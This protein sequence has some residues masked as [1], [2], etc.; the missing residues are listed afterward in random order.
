MDRLTDREGLAGIALLAMFADGLVREEED[1]E[2]REALRGTEAFADASD[3][4][5]G[6][7]LAKLEQL[8][9][10]MGQERFLRACCE[11]V[12]GDLADVAYGIAWDII[13][14]D[15]EVAPEESELLGKLEE[16]L[17]S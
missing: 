15:G 17:A 1:D 14:A 5:L 13:E 2:L 4:E 7:T 9:R 3:E 11:A 10:A 12:Q 6:T 16:L 8:S